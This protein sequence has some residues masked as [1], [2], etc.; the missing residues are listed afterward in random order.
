MKR[1]EIVHRIHT[2]LLRA[3]VT[4]IL[5]PR[6]CGK[7]TLGRMI[8]SDIPST[9]FDLEN[10]LDAS[11]LSASAM[12]TLENSDG[13]IIID[14][15][16]RQPELFP[17]LRVLADR[18]DR[19]F[20]FLILGSADPYLVKGTSESLAGRV[21]FVDISG[22]TIQEIGYNDYKKLWLRGGFPPSFL[23]DNEEDSYAWRSNYLRTFLERD[24][25]Q[26][27]IAIPA[28]TL[29]RFWTMI[30]HYHGKIWNASPFSASLSL[31]SQ[32]IRRYLDI[33]TGAYMLRRIPPWHE[34][35]K[36][37]QIKA[38]KIYL[39]DTGILHVLL[40]LRKD[41]IITHPILGAS[42]EGFV[43][44]QILTL[45]QTREF[46]FWG[47][48]AGAELDLL[49]FLHGKRYG[50]EV[51]YSDAP[52]R[53]KSMIIALHDLGLDELFVVFPGSSSYQMHDKI[54]ALGLADL[55][56]IMLKIKQY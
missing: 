19:Q 33:L 1:A 20:R 55:A 21:E 36:K 10:P 48:H 38:P 5:G 24:I 8:A 32:M 18:S 39:R 17:I 37:R 13:L 3:P 27:G 12:T 51:K 6:Q 14:E 47:T 44:E 25:P 9:Y 15:I 29:R 4:S 31:S 26:L 49:I 40:A 46:Y 45:L 53:T 54:T 35:I 52:K 2:A 42:W 43:I 23:A 41:A 22:F 34:N 16:Q 28:E 50:F 7:T 30:A 11:A 56:A